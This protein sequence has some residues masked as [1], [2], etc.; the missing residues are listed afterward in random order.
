MA[1]CIVWHIGLSGRVTYCTAVPGVGVTYGHM[2]GHLVNPGQKVLLPIGTSWRKKYIHSW[3]DMG[4]LYPGC[5]RSGFSMT[6]FHMYIWLV[7]PEKGFLLKTFTFK[8]QLSGQWK[9]IV[10]ICRIRV[11]PS[12]AVG[13][14]RR[15]ILFIWFFVSFQTYIQ[16]LSYPIISGVI[17]YFYKLKYCRS[18]S[19]A[20]HPIVPCL[21]HFSTFLFI[22]SHRILSYLD[23]AL[24]SVSGIWILP[25]DTIRG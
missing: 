15:A 21:D 2:D 13:T 1:I 3:R 8:F 11:S 4:C 17:T 16:I 24:T 5:L 23:K 6:T 20:R 18:Q 22:V 14:G 25:S 9:L 7:W 10:Q 12:E 19:P